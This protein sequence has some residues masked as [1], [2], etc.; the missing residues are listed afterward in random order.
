MK[1]LVFIVE[2]ETEESF[3]NDILRPYFYSEG[4]FNTIQCFKTKRS[5]GGLSKYSYVKQDIIQTIYESDVIV[6]TMLDFYRLPSN[7]PGFT[8]LGIVVPH[9]QQVEIL[10][11][12]MKE[13]IENTQQ[14]SFSNFIPYIQLHEFETLIFSSITGIDALFEKNEIDYQGLQTVIQQYPNPEDINNSPDTAPSVRLKKLIPGYNK[15]VHGIGIIQEIGIENI[16]CK[17]P[18]FNEWIIRL[19]QALNNETLL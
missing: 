10:E 13:D 14:M 18:R 17:C 3:V 15:V 12:K 5:H 6:T 11:A 8:Q 9:A 2:G 16:L 7:F 1:R 4:L 19:K